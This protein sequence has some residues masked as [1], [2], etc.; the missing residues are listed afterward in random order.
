MNQAASS[1]A[2]LWPV[3]GSRIRAFTELTKP[4]I[5]S[6]VLVSTAVGFGL[7][8]S[9]A[10][11]P[12]AAAWAFLHVMVGTSLVAA[13]ANSLNQLWEVE[14]DRLMQRTRNRPLPSGRLSA[15]EALLFGVFCS[16]TGLFYLAL[17]VNSLTGL[18]AGVTLATY[19]FLYTPLKRVTSLCVLAGAIPGA[20]PPVIGWT[21]AAGESQATAWMLFGIVFFWQ[22]PHFAA[23]AWLYREDYARGGFPL[24]AVMDGAGVRTDLHLVTNTVALIVVSLIP[25]IH[26]VAG[27]S[28]VF[29]A[30]LLG[31]AFLASGCL[32]LVH[33][34]AASA[35]RHVLASVIYLPLLL[36]LL[37]WDK[38]TV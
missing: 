5:L 25:G 26:G 11:N 32:F 23:I 10:M 33:K 3:T 18:L 34:S 4:R 16:S 37:L 19:L 31:L 14:H 22:L 12:A 17:L 20:L 6:L 21:A 8:L 13:G 15:T 28:Y 29:G 24:L 9:P 1:L 2:T 27:R 35:R 30:M 38:T 36:G 7:G